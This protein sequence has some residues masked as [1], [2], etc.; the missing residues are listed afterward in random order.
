[1]KC[2]A[3]LGNSAAGFL[4][5]SYQSWQVSFYIFGVVGII[6]GIL[7]VSNGGLSPPI[8][9]DLSKFIE[10]LLFFFYVSID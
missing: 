4:I 6:I 5:F 2:G 8:S 7:Y 9:R 10:Y 1:M 3:I